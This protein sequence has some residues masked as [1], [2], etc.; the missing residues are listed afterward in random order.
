MYS[1]I[2]RDVGCH[3]RGRCETSASSCWL[4]EMLFTLPRSLG[5]P[6]RVA[7]A[8]NLIAKKCCD[9]RRGSCGAKYHGEGIMPRFACELPVA[10]M[11]SRHMGFRPPDGPNRNYLYR[12]G[13]IF[14]RG[15]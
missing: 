7:A 12:E 3:A 8:S 14:T 2:E 13:S 11:Y 10:R 4:A 9:F 15:T 1:I 5:I 6:M